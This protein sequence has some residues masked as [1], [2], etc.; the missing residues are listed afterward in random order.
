MAE[1]KFKCAPQNFKHFE[2][3]CKSSECKVEDKKADRFGVITYKVS[4]KTVKG[5]NEFSDK[6]KS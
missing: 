1:K 3:T 2:E 6:L 4:C 5:L